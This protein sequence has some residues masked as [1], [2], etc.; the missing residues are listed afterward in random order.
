[1]SQRPKDVRKRLELGQWELDTIISS[2]EKSKAGLSTFVERKT[3]LTKIRIKTNRKA[4]TFNEHCIIALGECGNSNLKSLTVDCGK[5]F[6]GYLELEDKL[7]LDVYFDDAYSSG[8]K[9]LMEI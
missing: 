3:R 7:N 2:R 9:E 4:S 8:K 6:T 5:E 1:M